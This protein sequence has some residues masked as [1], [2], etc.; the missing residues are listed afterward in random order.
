MALKPLPLPTQPLVR[1]GG[2]GAQPTQPWAEYL[3]S[4]DLLLRT[5]NINAANDAAAAAAGVAIGQL[6]RNGN[7][8]QIRLT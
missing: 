6:Y 5:I 3:K 2:E 4:V 1:A 8:I 7:T